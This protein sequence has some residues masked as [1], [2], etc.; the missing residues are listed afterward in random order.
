MA[1]YTRT[2]KRKPP[3]VV[4]KKDTK[5]V[6]QRISVCSDCKR[7][8]YPRHERLWTSRGLVHNPCDGEAGCN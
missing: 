6:D 7:G 4:S 2:D 8:I 5:N 1:T 3:T